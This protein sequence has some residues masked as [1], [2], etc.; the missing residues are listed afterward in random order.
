[1]TSYGF[2][3]K[4]AERYVLFTR[5]DCPADCMLTR[6][7]SVVVSINVSVGPFLGR[8]DGRIVPR[9][10][11]E[12]SRHHVVLTYDGDSEVR[13]SNIAENMTSLA[14]PAAIITINNKRRRQ[15]DGRKV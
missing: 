4:T 12:C 11:W 5:V 1:M 14:A 15:R 7:L 10:L 3:Q 13:K 6:P 9:K 8:S 2:T